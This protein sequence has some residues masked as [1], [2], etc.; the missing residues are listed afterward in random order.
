MDTAVEDPLYFFGRAL[1]PDTPEWFACFDGGS[2]EGVRMF[3]VTE[4]LSPIPKLPSTPVGPAFGGLSGAIG[5]DRATNLEVFRSSP[6]IPHQSL[7]REV[8]SLDP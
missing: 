2:L 4:P 6:S 8:L 7:N 3:V 1:D 5:G